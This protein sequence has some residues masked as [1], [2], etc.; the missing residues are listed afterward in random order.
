M[1]HQIENS[2]V[3]FCRPRRLSQ[4]EYEQAD[5]MVEEMLKD[6]II[7]PS[8]SPFNAPIILVTK[9][10]GTL[11]FCVDFRRLNKVTKTS[12]Y[13]LTNPMSCFEKLNK[14]FYFT[15]LDLAA[16]YWTVPMAEEDKEKTAFTVRSG[17]YEFNVMPFG[18]TN[19]VATF[20]ALMDKIFSGLQ[21]DFLLCFLDDILIFSPEDFE[22]HLKQLSQVLVRLKNANMRLKLSKCKICV[23]EVDYLGYTVGR[24]GLKM[25]V[26]KLSAIEAIKLPTT[27][28]EVRSFI[29]MA[30]YYRSFI[31]DF[32]GI[33]VPLYHAL[34][35][36]QPTKVTI[37]PEFKEA[38]E[39]L[40]NK[41]RSYP[42]L[43]FPDFNKPF[44]LETDASI[45]RVAAALMQ[46]IDGKRVLISCAGKTLTTAQKNYSPVELEAL[47][48]IWGIGYYRPYLFGRNF[49]LITDHESLKFLY[50]FQNPTGRIVRWILALQEYSF[51]VIY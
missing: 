36:D 4:I 16:A 20:C 47:A 51:E 18:L 14:A 33:A 8:S 50:N 37:T 43:R 46:D 9:K 29:G 49:T 45:I 19:A 10:D 1:E 23:P 6:N 30:G 40:K 11:R 2:E 32:T 5:K 24:F 26:K 48:V 17:K 38:F 7:R 28:T 25:Q 42:I 27:K 21:W 22:L 3:V 34:E 31:R 44:V 12:K 39:E 15:S 41:L 13:P 35:D